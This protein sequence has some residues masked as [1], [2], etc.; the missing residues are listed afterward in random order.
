MATYA[1]DTSV[2]TEKSRAEIERTLQRWGA[3]QFMYGWTG[4]A[5]VV[6]FILANRKVKFVVP[7]PDRNAREFTHT[8][9]RGTLRSPAQHAE[10]YEQACRQRWRALSLVIKA[11]LEAVESGISTF[12][13]EFLGHLVLPNGQTVADSVVPAVAE[14]YETH[15]MPE[16]LPEYPAPRAIES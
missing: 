13:V 7:M 1:A 6:G 11:K 8:P 15:R 4:Q 10:A 5:A 16:L 3:E 2:S 9:A 12:D 14:A